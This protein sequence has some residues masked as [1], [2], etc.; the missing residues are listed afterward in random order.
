M[1][2]E[3]FHKEFSF[4]VAVLSKPTEF[5]LLKNQLLGISFSFALNLVVSGDR[6]S[7]TVVLYFSTNQN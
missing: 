2:E 7:I 1:N 5:S 3:N 4:H 6:V